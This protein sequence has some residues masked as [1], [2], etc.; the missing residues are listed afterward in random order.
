MCMGSL[1][2]QSRCTTAR[3]VL[4]TSAAVVLL[5][6]LA[7]T[8]VFAH[9][10]SEEVLAVLYIEGSAISFVPTVKAEGWVL[11]VTSQDGT[12]TRLEFSA[13]ETPV[14]ELGSESSRLTDGTYSYSLRPTG[15]AEG[16]PR[17]Q[18]GV[19]S[20]EEGEITIE[21][22]EPGS[23]VDL[24]G[25]LEAGG[26]ARAPAIAMQQVINNNLVVN[27]SQCIGFDCPTSGPS[28]GFTTLGLA[29]H[30][31][32][33]QFHD[34]STAASFPRNDW[35]IQINDSANGGLN[36]FGVIDCGTNA[37][38][39]ACGG[40]RVFAIEAGAPTNSLFVDDGGRLG[41]KT[42]TPSTE[43][44]SRHGDTPTLRLQQDG[45]S[46]FA[47]QTWDVAGNE[48]NFF[49]RDVTNGSSLPF[50]IRPGA[51]TS[52]ID[53]DSEGEVGIG[54]SSPDARIDIEVGGADRIGVLVNTAASPVASAQEWHVDGA[55]AARLR[56]RDDVRQFFLDDFDNGAGV[57]PQVFIDRNS[58]STPSAGQLVLRNLGNQLY[59]L[60]PDTSGDLRIH[61]D[62]AT[63]ATDTAGIVVGDQTSWHA[64]KSYEPWAGNGALEAV[65]GTDLYRF[66]Y[67]DTGYEDSRG[68]SPW[69]YGLVGFERDAWFL[70]NVG[71]H[72]V[73]SLNDLNLF[74]Y[75]IAS[76]KALNT[77]IETQ[78]EQIDDLETR[79]GALEAVLNGGR[80]E[81]SGP[82]RKSR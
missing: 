35:L 57:G 31:L 59:A 12:V 21:S 68:E 33:I 71:P 66:Q 17:V 1:W 22:G 77:K 78:Q 8:T 70:K 29:E 81:G 53:V 26:V 23:V 24:R 46:G 39:A 25:M 61:T 4:I 79:L 64:F 32:R 69:F 38:L 65:V 37:A 6:S 40:T 49:I 15:P 80:P 20:L 47:P 43:I 62:L 30:N 10:P 63:N 16:E 3:T 76:V 60:W 44:H 55:L 75:L 72:Q 11:E 42:S 51:P 9:Q 18:S 74:G 27:G 14:L 82:D 28:F 45:S 36:F 52:S 7:P 34:T 13:D 5:A 50:R 41:L 73:P 2:L 48:T 58:S 19:F 67:L 56:L 54:T